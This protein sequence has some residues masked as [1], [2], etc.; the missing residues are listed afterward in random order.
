MKDKFPLKIV[1][2]DQQKNRFK[3][4]TS[5][6]KLNEKSK[7]IRQELAYLEEDYSVLIKTIRDI[8]AVSSQ[9]RRTDPR[10]YWLVGDMI[11]RFLER[12][13]DIGFYLMQQN[14]TLARDIGVSQSSIEKI[15]SFRRR[16]SK[17][18]MVNPTIP[19]AK[20]RDNKVPV[21]NE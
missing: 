1:T 20:Y 16:F 6:D 11:I 15:V 13:D 10:L 19:W 12:I 5:M 17:L 8:I 2:S 14:N 18:S 4:T 9:S 3:A 7:N 21:V